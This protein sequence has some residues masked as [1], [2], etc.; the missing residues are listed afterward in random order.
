MRIDGGVAKLK[1]D[2]EVQRLTD[3]SEVLQQRGIFFLQSSKL[4]FIDLFFAPRHPLQVLL[5]P[6]SR[7]PA[8]VPPNSVPA[9]IIPSLAARAFMARFDLS[10]YDLLAPSLQFHD[11]WTHQLLPYETIFRAMEYEKQRGPHIVLLPDHPV[12][13]K[14]FLCVRG[15]REYHSHPQHSGDDWFL[16]RGSISL[17]ST[18]MTLW[19]V[20]VDLVRPQVILQPT[21]THFQLIANWVAETKE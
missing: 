21:P 1:Y 4:P 14:P 17:F 5:P 20:A 2:S 9:V 12:T 15:V 19:R 8:G 13:H 10:D 11:P 18:V 16:Y 3:Q 7:L 6:P